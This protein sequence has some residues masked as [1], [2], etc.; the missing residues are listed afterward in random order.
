MAADSQCQQ[1][2]NN[3]FCSNPSVKKM[4]RKTCGICQ[5]CKNMAAD[6]Q[7]QQYFN[8]GFCSNPSVK[9]M[10]RKTCGSC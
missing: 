5:D 1:Y 4:C 2:L 10:C 8:N 9:K 7:C 3:G 6:S